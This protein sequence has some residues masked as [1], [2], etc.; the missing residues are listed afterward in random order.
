MISEAYI[1][2]SSPENTQVNLF[3]VNASGVSN[4][5]NFFLFRLAGNVIAIQ[6]ENANEVTYFPQG[7]TNYPR[8]NRVIF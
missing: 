7:V 4:S 1:F 3:L 2:S 8:E 6:L 5:R